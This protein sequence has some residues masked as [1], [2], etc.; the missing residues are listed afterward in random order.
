M[1]V[2][3]GTSGFSYKPWKGPFYPETLPDGDMLKFYASRFRT[4]EINN[5]FYRMPLKTALAAWDAET[6]AGFRFSLKAPQR[7]TNSKKQDDDDSYLA[8]FL[9]RVKLLGGK[10]GPLLFQFPRWA[11]QDLDRLGTLLA[12]LPRSRNI[13]VEF[14]HDS[15]L[16]DAVYALL[17]EHGAMLCTADKD[18][19]D[20]PPLVATSGTGYVRLRRVE[21]DDRALGEWVERIASMPWSTAYVYFKHEDEGLG[22]KF[23]ARFGELWQA[24]HGGPAA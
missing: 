1:D 7:I 18:T 24:A 3:A 21:Y 16:D 15:W 11:K 13:A 10:L 4:V 14:L 22:P 23:A 2:L 6:P 17:R 20:P 9:E 8:E 12:A 5:T 19:G